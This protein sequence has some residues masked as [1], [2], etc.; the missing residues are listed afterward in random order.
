MA[1]G[2]R[3]AELVAALSL[4]TDL[5]MGQPMEQALRTCLIALSL[6]REMG[7]EP[8]QMRDVYYVALLRFLGCTSDAYENAAIV[9][10]DEL[11]FRAA[12]TA[13]TFAM[14]AGELARWLSE[15]PHTGEAAPD[16]RLQD[17]DGVPVRLSDLRGKPV[18]LEFGS[19][20][21]PIFSDRVIDMERL[22]QRHPEAEFLVIAVREAH[23][24]EV[25]GHHNTL[26][27]KRQAA[28]CL[29]IEEGL[30]RR[31]LIDDLEGSVHGAYGGG[32]DPGVCHRRRG[33][34]CIPARL[35]SPG[36]SS[37]GAGGARHRRTLASRRNHRHGGAAWPRAR[38]P[39]TAGARWPRRA[40]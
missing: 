35:E 15:G 16:F 36:R 38:R 39:A 25:T 11:A 18:V 23:P 24:G 20:T 19:Y 2:L 8:D 22:A 28:R 37:A 33:H 27:Q 32:W 7:L 5:G 40:A 6:G 29:A 14:D 26:A 1:E 34:G 30:R 3:L 4:V 13:Y 17:L 10:G 31:V 9:G 21:C 12:V